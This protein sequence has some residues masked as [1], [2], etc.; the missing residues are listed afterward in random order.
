MAIR[1]LAAEG[2]RGLTHRAVDRAADLP[3]G[4]TPYYVRTRQAL[5]ERFPR[6]RPAV[7]AGEVP[8][9]SDM[10]IYGVHRLPAAW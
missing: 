2:M 7:P 4:S 1:L 8:T 6:L 5:L 9:R 10:T 3:D